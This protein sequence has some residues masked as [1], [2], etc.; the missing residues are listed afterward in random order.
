MA[1]VINDIISKTPYG[2]TAVLP[3]GEYEGPVYIT[4]PLRLVGNNTTIWAKRG[5]IIEITARGCAVENLRVELT[6][7]SVSETAIKASYQTIIRGVEVAGAVKGFGAEDG[8]F[9]LPRSLELGE[10]P[11][12][13]VST[14]YMTVNIPAPAEI[15]CKTPGLTFTPSSLAAGRNKVEIA[16]SGIS[17]QTFLYSEVLIKTMF[18]RRMYVS[19]KAVS[20]AAP[21]KGKPVYD[22]PERQ[23]PL[24]SP[25]SADV[26]TVHSPVPIY[27]VPL[28]EMK[29][30]QRASLYQYIGTKC[31]IRFNCE[32]PADMEID[33]YAFLL[34]DNEKSLGESGLVF[35]GNESSLN[36]EVRYF[37]S[38][39]HIEID[40]DKV[41]YKARKIAVA[42]S[43]YAGNVYKSFGRVRA[44]VISILAGGMERIS[45]LMDGLYNETTVVAVEFYIYKGEWKISAV[46]AGYRDGMA[47]LC[48][49]Y[50]IEVID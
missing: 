9:D 14:F 46:G 45:F 5:S 4:K 23:T 3:S 27:D 40:F 36:N 7:G 48:N 31:E 17:P 8:R 30:G 12:G 19:G 34:D 10:F 28:L 15:E 37:P 50:G 44:P 16:V 47:K 33:P 25:S 26:I 2:G 21:V 39:G 49:H 22:A 18:T 11:S 35:F 6:E 13:G 24:S 41:D 29:K 20:N 38:D 42:Y 1:E 32:K 43:I